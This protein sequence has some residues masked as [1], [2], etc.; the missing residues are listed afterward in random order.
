LQHAIADLAAQLEEA[1]A[2]LAAE[3]TKHAETHSSLTSQLL[4]AQARRA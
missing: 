2:A 4:D 3:Q 1:K